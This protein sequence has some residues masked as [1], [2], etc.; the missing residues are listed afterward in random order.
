MLY[1]FGKRL[2]RLPG[3][4]DD[5][6]LIFFFKKKA[7]Y[8]VYYT[9]MYKPTIYFPGF[10]E[11]EEEEERERKL[12]RATCLQYVDGFE[13]HTGVLFLFTALLRILPN[14]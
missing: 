10:K 3:E 12:D 5:E 7:V 14:L 13:I 8:L 4:T 6:S 1:G 9:N 11:E 2:G